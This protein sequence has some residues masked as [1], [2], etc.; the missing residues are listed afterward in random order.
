MQRSREFLLIAYKTSSAALQLD[1]I[2]IS[3]DLTGSISF[4]LFVVG[5]LNVD[6]GVPDVW[7]NRV[8]IV[9]H[10]DGCLLCSHLQ[11]GLQGIK[12][13]LTDNV[14]PHHN[15]TDQDKDGCFCLSGCLSCF[16]LWP[17]HPLLCLNRM[18]ERLC[19]TL[20]SPYCMLLQQFTS[21][22]ESVWLEKTSVNCGF[23]TKNLCFLTHLVPAQPNGKAS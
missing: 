18:Q 12:P 19:T 21:P 15:T 14:T 13:E 1:M 20:I 22:R 6:G 2:L 17:L 10:C 4:E 7:R 9:H 23:S 3:T 8:V 11:E 16:G 5:E